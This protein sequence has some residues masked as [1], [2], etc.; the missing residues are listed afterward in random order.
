M[1]AIN[2]YVTQS[3]DAR[4]HHL[5]FYTQI[6]GGGGGGGGDDTLLH[7]DNDFSKSWLFLST[8]SLNTNTETLSPAK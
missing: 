4:K 3:N 2:H 5:A 7:K 6:D 1:S 8:L